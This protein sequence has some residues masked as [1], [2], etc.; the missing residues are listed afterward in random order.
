VAEGW[1]D[2]LREQ[3]TEGCNINGRVRVNKVAG[4]IHLSPG[5]SFQASNYQN[6][7]ELV[8]Y[9]KEEGQRH[10]FTHTIH[11]LAFSAD[12]EYDRTKSKSSAE[13]KKRL[14][15]FANP[16]DQAEWAVCPC[17]KLVFTLDI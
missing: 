15:I 14:G 11:Q 3:S 1:A 4:N 7:Y 2:K 8:P 9:L 13:L 17:N 12:D 16:L 5:R 10:D 6:V